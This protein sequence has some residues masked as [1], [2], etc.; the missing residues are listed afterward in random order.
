MDFGA[1]GYVTLYRYAGEGDALTVL[2]LRHQLEAG[3]EPQGQS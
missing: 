1:G 2:A 3:D